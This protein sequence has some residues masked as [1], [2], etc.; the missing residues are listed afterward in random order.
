MAVGN[1]LTLMPTLFGPAQRPAP[2][3]GVI[4][5]G[6]SGL[7]TPA[8]EMARIDLIERM[9]VTKTNGANN[10]SSLSL[11]RLLGPTLRKD[12]P[13]FEGVF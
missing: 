12:R 3:G 5:G 7:P 6:F 10:K 2:I 4:S 11:P 13:I 1:F 8:I 9:R